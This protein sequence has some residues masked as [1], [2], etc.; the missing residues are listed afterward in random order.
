MTVEKQSDIHTVTQCE[1]IN[2]RNLLNLQARY[3]I[4][5]DCHESNS[6]DLC[7]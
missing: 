6:A 3:S 5:N 1:Y 2:C 4:Q 7:N